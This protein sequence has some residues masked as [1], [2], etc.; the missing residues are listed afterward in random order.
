M[1]QSY[2]WDVTNSNKPI[3]ELTPPSPLCCLRYNPK[4][5]DTLVGGSYN[6]TISYYDLRKPNGP[7]GKCGPAETSVIEK[8]HHDPVSDVFWVSSKTGHQCVLCANNWL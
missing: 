8:S 5:S 1:P 4:S 3:V 6:G 2:I 7:A